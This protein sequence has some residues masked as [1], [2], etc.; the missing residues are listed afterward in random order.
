MVLSERCDEQLVRMACLIGLGGELKVVLHSRRAADCGALSRD[1]IAGQDGRP[2]WT[3]LLLG[4]DLGWEEA[5]ESFQRTAGRQ[6][7][8]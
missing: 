2:E 1:E 7:V 4:D 8:S 5:W 3:K 6:S